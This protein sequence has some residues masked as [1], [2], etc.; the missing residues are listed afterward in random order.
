M[1]GSLVACGV[2]HLT[3][4][5]KRAKKE[6]QIEEEDGTQPFLPLETRRSPVRNDPMRDDSVSTV[7][8]RLRSPT[9][10]VC[11]KVFSY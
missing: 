7:A 1:L 5:S 4:A 11:V 10:Y 3:K 8:D 9:D 6:E 2:I